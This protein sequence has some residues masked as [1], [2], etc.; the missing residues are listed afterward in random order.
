MYGLLI[1]STVAIK[2]DSYESIIFGLLKIFPF[3]N[4]IYL[5]DL[6]LDAAIGINDWLLFVLT[7]II[8][9]MIGYKV[10]DIFLKYAK[11]KG[12]INSY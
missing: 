11:K 6:S 10:F 9:L 3:T 4:A 8:V 12:I 2:A 5:S 1:V 7:N